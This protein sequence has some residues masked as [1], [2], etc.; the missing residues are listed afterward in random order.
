MSD[1][2][3]GTS[4]SNPIRFRNYLIYTWAEEDTLPFVYHHEGYSFDNEADTRIGWAKTVDAAREMIGA[5]S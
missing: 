1:R 3:P 5:A 2:I 4:S